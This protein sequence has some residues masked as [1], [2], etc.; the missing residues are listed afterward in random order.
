M[1]IDQD[2]RVAIRAAAKNQP[3][4]DY[5]AERAFEQAEIQRV[6]TA[7]PLRK[8]LHILH[9]KRIANAKRIL[10]Q[11]ESFY[12]DLGLSYELRNIYHDGKFK[13]AGGKQPPEHSTWR[14]EK[15][16]AQLTAA[17]PA[18]GRTL[19]KKYGINWE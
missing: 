8:R 9:Q 14:A 6:V 3:A 10:H 4:R 1:K 11:A 19:L 16:I 18:E 2:L 7:T 13:A 5:A 12:S 17:S 15:L